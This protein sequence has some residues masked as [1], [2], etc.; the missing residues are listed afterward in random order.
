MPIRTTEQEAQ[1]QELKAEEKAAL[2]ELDLRQQAQRDELAGFYS[3]KWDQL[4]TSQ[5]YRKPRR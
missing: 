3:T 2:A 1:V 5:G 4:W